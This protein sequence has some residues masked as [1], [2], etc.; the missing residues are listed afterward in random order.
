MDQDLVQRRR[1]S[2][3]EVTLR[4]ID[5]L[6]RRGVTMHERL[7]S[8]HRLCNL[9]RAIHGL[10]EDMAAERA[11]LW[12]TLQDRVLP[13]CS[14]LDDALQPLLHAAAYRVLVP[15]EL[16]VAIDAS[17]TLQVGVTQ[18]AAQIVRLR[19][20]DQELA[21]QLG[22]LHDRARRLTP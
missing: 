10:S 9:A 12:A 3:T 17:H 15:T 19:T 21:L 7:Q 13:A 11:G 20:R 1:G 8:V 6:A 16:V 22:E 4:A 2:N 5:E 18:A 14:E